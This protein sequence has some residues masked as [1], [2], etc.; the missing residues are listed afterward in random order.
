MAGT[1]VISG[2]IDVDPEVRDELIAASVPL[3]QSTRNDEPGCLAYVFAADPAVDG[4]IHIFEHWASA[5]DLDA[6][7]QHP[8]FK[9]TGE[10]LRS[11]GFNLRVR[12]LALLAR[13]RELFTIAFLMASVGTAIGYA[14]FRRGAVDDDPDGIRVEGETRTGFEKRK[15][16]R[17]KDDAVIRNL[18]LSRD[19]WTFGFGAP[20]GDDF[21]SGINRL[22]SLGGLRA[23]GIAKSSSAAKCSTIC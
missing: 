3:Q 4:R 8:N 16:A 7:F 22:I 14:V 15:T 17:P 9:A 20:L 21:G 10:L 18:N 13:L 6:H 11:M 23:S 1:I 19:R 5:A 2:F 12:K